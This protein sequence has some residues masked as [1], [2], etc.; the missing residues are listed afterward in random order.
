M[1]KLDRRSLLRGSAALAATG[2]L[3]AFGPA[4]R[5]PVGRLHWAGSETGVHANGSLGGAVD[6]GERAAREV[7]EQLERSGDRQPALA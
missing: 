1:S 3:T 4:L 2:A 7:V 5:A 6:A